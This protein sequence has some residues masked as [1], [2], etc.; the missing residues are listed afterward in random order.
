MIQIA[1]GKS[2]KNFFGFSL[3]EIKDLKDIPRIIP[4][5]IGDVIAFEGNDRRLYAHRLVNINND[6]FTTKG[7]NF[8]ESKPYEINVP[9]KNIQGL[10]VWSKPSWK[11]RK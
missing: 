8:T 3:L 4:L 7:D 6:R 1:T 11:K 2:M 10:V 5:E 9:V